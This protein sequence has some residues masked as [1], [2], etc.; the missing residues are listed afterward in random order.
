MIAKLQYGEQIAEDEDDMIAA[1]DG[2]E[3]VGVASPIFIKEYDSYLVFMTIYGTD[4]S[5][6]AKLKLKAWRAQTG[7]V[8]PKVAICDGSTVSE[9]ITYETDMVYGSLSAPYLLTAQDYIEQGIALTEGWNWISFYTLPD[10][11]T[12]EETFRSVTE[13]YNGSDIIHV[14]GKDYYWQYHNTEGSGGS[15]ET[16]SLSEMYMAFLPEA[17]DLLVAGQ[18]VSPADVPITL[19]NGWSWIGVPLEGVCAIERAFADAEP[20]NGD[21]IKSKTK[22]SVYDGSRWIGEI[23]YLAPGNGYEYYY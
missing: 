21:L 18:R 5:P 7:I 22:F 6:D 9:T 23:A 12:P 20:C 10:D 1:F 19:N 2:D 13:S 17:A 14:K 15:L 11:N 16:M 4:E 8:Y 3:C